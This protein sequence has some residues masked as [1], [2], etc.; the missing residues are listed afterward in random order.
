MVLK[1]LQLFCGRNI[2]II[3]EKLVLTEETINLLA[4][5]VYKFD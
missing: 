2:I 1:N 3:S 4:T 5:K